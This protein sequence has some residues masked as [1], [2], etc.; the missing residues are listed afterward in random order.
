MSA[1]LTATIAGPSA[2]RG[3]VLAHETSWQSEL[4]RAEIAG[5]D[6]ALAAVRRA[7]KC[8]PDFTKSDFPLPA[9]QTTL[10]HLSEE[11][12]PSDAR[13]APVGRIVAWGH[14]IG[15]T[16]IGR[17]ALDRPVRDELHGAAAQPQ[18][19]RRRELERAVED[20]VRRVRRGPDH[21]AEW[22]Q[23][24]ARHPGQPAQLALG[25]VAVQGRGDAMGEVELP[26][27]TQDAPG[28]QG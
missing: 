10:T 6:S 3:A 7:G 12:L 5:L 11:L 22:Q 2:W 17:V 15:A 24:Q 25:S 9:W 26:G 19:V 23:A 4:S 8:F 27:A 14:V 28:I 20:R 18:H 1:I 13:I 16:Q 21:D